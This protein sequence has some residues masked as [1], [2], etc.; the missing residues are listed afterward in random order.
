[1]TL[2]HGDDC[3]T[4][5]CLEQ[6]KWLEEELSKRFEMKTTRL[7]DEPECQQEA[8]VLNRIVRVTPQR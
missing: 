1:M 7:G 4:V 5:G 2:V 8:R 6:V 3:V